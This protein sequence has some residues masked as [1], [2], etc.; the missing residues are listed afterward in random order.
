VA[1]GTYLDGFGTFTERRPGWAMKTKVYLAIFL[2]ALLPTC[3]LGCKGGPLQ[4]TVGAIGKTW[5]QIKVEYVGYVDQD[6]NLDSEQKTIRKKTADQ[7][8][9]LIRVAEESYRSEK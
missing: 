3:L 2:C 7:L 1:C 8:S 9:D 4:T 6:P 5:E